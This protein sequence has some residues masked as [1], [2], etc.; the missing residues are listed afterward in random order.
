VILLAIVSYPGADLVALSIRLAPQSAAP[1]PA[2]GALEWL[3]VAHPHGATPFIA[4]P[5][6]RRVELRGTVVAGLIDFWSG[7]MEDNSQ[8]PPL[9][10]IDPAAYANGCPANYLTIRNPPLCKNDFA[11]MRALGFNVVR[12]A[13]SWSLLEPQPG[14]Y[15]TEYVNR[16][17]QVVG[18]ARDQGIY[19]ILDMHENAYSRYIPRPAKVTLPGG[20]LPSLADQTGAP[21][22][23]TLTGAL[24]GDKFLGQRE[25]SLSVGE[26]FTNFWLNAKVAGEGLQDHYLG[27]VAT[28]A[29]RFKDESA[30][31]GFGAF[32]EPWPGFVPPPAADDLLIYPFYRR[33]IDAITGVA[34]GVRCPSSFPALPICGHPSLGVDDR[35]HIFFLEADHVRELTDFPVAFGLPVSSYPNLAFSIHPYTH[36]YTLDAL[37]GQNPKTSPYPPA[38]YGQAYGTAEAEARSMDAALFV[39]EFGN[40]PQL[41]GQ[42]LTN[43]LQQQDRYLTGAT[44]WPWKENCGGDT[45]GVY[46]GPLGDV[47]TSCA[48]QQK[49]VSTG[50]QPENG[51]LRLAKERLLARPT[52]LAAVGTAL[53]YAYDPVSGAFSLSATAP[54]GNSL[55]TVVLVPK[56]ITGTISQPS[57]PLPEGSRTVSFVPSGAYALTIAAAPLR[58]T[59]C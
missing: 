10:P 16:V 36:K 54:K 33:L 28:L 47:K 51:C 23:A 8:P 43:E 44:Y 15:S 12:L 1:T 38:G 37:A 50:V 4:D 19:V 56:E 7:T 49:G 39:S 25:M 48:Y 58:L 18:W 45:W 40:E 30:V 27:A 55:A 6:G 29:R 59:G 35:R 24:P 31:V 2:G 17:A 42:L 20:A 5:E 14:Q 52:V 41:D 46:S 22:W 21:K 9:F 11:E 3:H 34:D 57:V 26:A 13:L 53:K 32:N